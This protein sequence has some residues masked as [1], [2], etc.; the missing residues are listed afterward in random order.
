MAGKSGFEELLLAA[1]AGNEDAIM[2]MFRMY[3]PLLVKNAM[4]RNVFDD[5]LYQ[6]LC[7]V[8]MYCIRVF[9]I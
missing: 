6:E 4:V 3:Q 2:E 9:K 8:L 7:V 5:D 1:K